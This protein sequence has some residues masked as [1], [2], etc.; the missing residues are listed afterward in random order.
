MKKQGIRIL[1]VLT[2]LMLILSV[3]MPVFA[4]DSGNGAAEGN[5][6][7]TVDTAPP[8]NDPVYE[9]AE[10]PDEPGPSPSL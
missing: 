5:G 6:T 3:L 2:A 1:A 9:E 4:E 10:E 7:G 8:S